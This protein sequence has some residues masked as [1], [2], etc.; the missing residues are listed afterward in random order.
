MSNNVH[1]LDLHTRV[2][3][4]ISKVALHGVPRA[5]MQMCVNEKRWELAFLR[6]W[7]RTRRCPHSV[8]ISPNKGAHTAYHD[9]MIT[10]SI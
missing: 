2:I 3:E 10:T 1:T 7:L 9:F 5:G 6:R 8:K 4:D